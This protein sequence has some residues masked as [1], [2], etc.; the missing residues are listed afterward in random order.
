MSLE[1]GSGHAPLPSQKISEVRVLPVVGQLCARQAVVLGQGRQAPLPSH[2]PSL[3][4]SA[5]FAGSLFAQRDLGSEPPLS[6]LEQVPEGAVL[7]PLHVLHRLP[8]VASAQ[9]VLQHT[10]SVQKPLWH[11]VAA[12]QAAPL[13][14]RPQEPTPPDTSHVAG[15]TQSASVA[16]VLLHAPDR[17]MKGSQGLASGVAQTPEPSHVEAGVTEDGLAHVAGLQLRPLA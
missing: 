2:V 9:A 14:F 13:G 8:E 15:G 5:L 11:R 7:V 10:P 3:V 1:L 6:T 17:H 12:V 16:Q 4:Q